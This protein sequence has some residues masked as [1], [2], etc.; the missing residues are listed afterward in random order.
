MYAYVGDAAAAAGTTAAGL[1]LLHCPAEH[2]GHA[3]APPL[4]FVHGAFMGAWCWEQHYLSH[5]AGLGYD[6]HALSFRG[7]GG[8]AGRETLNA[9]SLGDYAADL[10]AAV[11]T[12]GRPPVLIGH[13]MGGLVLDIALRRGMPAAGAVFLAAVPP[14]GLVPSGVQVALTEPRAF[15]QLGM[16]QGA[17]AAWV[18]PEQAQRALLAQELDTDTLLD[19]TSRMQPESQLALFEMGFP[20]WPHWGSLG[21]PVGVIGA[22]ADAIIPAWL[23]ES[24]AWLYGVR[25]RWIPDTGHAAMLEPGWQ[26]G[27]EAVAEALG[28]LGL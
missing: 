13:S 16:L 22:A 26:P 17:G 23:I 14:M 3:E 10:S 1:E 24:A 5:F 20:R 12:L 7:H 11:A 19:Y 18:S 4:L 8:S 6:A 25:P 27:A 15:W 2:D 21:C 9:A 28:D